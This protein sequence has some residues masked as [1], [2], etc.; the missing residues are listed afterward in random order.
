MDWILDSNIN[1]SITDI[2][3]N[4]GT[5]DQDIIVGIEDK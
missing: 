4:V 1:S 5:T 3:P 2:I